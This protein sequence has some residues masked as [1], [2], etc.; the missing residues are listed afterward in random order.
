MVLSTLRE[1]SFQRQ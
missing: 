1:R